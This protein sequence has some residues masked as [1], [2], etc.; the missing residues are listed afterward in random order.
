M[1]SLKHLNLLTSLCI[2]LILFPMQ[3]FAFVNISAL[4]SSDYTKT[5]DAK[6]KWKKLPPKVQFIITNA[7]A[8][9]GE[10]SRGKGELLKIL[11]KFENINCPETELKA[12]IVLQEKFN[13]IE[14]SLKKDLKEYDKFLKKQKKI[15][16]STDKISKPWPVYHY[17]RIKVE[18]IIQEKVINEHFS[19]TNPCVRKISKIKSV[20]NQKVKDKYIVSPHGYSNILQAC[21]TH[22]YN[23]A[24]SEIDIKTNDFNAALIKLKNLCGSKIDKNSCKCIRGSSKKGNIVIATP[25]KDPIITKAILIN[26]RF[27]ERITLFSKDGPIDSKN[28]IKDQERRMSVD[29]MNINGFFGSLGWNEWIKYENKDNNGT[30]KKYHISQ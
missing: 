24:C 16:N 14:L 19:G 27:L 6:E 2:F 20:K 3:N 9:M 10:I 22:R 25:I 4:M 8:L 18:N 5:K 13:E 23:I 15:G 28:K 7:E 11:L 1:E 17:F 12:R 30:L 26:E 29:C 21:G